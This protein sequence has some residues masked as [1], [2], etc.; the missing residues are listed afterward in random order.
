VLAVDRLADL[1]GTLA[2]LSPAT[3]KRLD[4]ALPPI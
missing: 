4:A 1:D 3:M 2:A